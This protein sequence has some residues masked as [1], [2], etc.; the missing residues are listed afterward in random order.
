MSVRDRSQPAKSAEEVG[1]L[2]NPALRY[3]LEN[4]VGNRR[5]RKRKSDEEDGWMN[6]SEDSDESAVQRI[7]SVERIVGKG[8][9][10]REDEDA[11]A[12]EE[13]DG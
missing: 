4:D 8:S 11:D 2:G 9:G 12:D 7:G 1:C 10:Q 13:E 5:K 6:E 3:E